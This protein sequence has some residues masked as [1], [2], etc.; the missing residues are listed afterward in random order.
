MADD[1]HRPI[2]LLGCTNTY[3]DPKRIE[4]LQAEREALARLFQ[5][6]Q[7]DLTVKVADPEQKRY[8]FDHIRKHWHDP[9]MQLLHLSGYAAGRYFHFEGGA[10]EESLT[11]D[12]L[13]T[14]IGRLP[15]LQ[16][17]CLSG[18]ATTELLEKLLLLDIPAILVASVEGRERDQLTA[19]I[20]TFYQALAAGVSLRAA[21]TQL[22]EADPEHR[23]GWY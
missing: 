19:G 3:Q 13:A 6:Q 15:G 20:E 4:Q 1:P 8:F 22:Q 17:V 12:R 2:I 14:V 10:G 16:L 11:A 9:A 18:C 23:W 5:D 21:F 7:P